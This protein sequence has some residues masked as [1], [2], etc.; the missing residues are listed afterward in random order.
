MIRIKEGVDIAGLRPEILLVLP[1]AE[2][3]LKEMSWSVNIVITSG[4][5]GKH[6]IGSFHYNGLAIDL[7]TREMEPGQIPHFV[8]HMKTCLGVQFD[9]VLEDTHLH[10][11]FQPKGTA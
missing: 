2:S 7:R 10:I 5:D 4:R 8:Q 6:S 9:V 11:E 1:V 3:I